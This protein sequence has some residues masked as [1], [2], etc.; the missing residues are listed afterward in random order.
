[1]QRRKISIL[2]RDPVLKAYLEQQLNGCGCLEI[3]ESRVRAEATVM[4]HRLLTENERQLLQKVADC[5][6]V[7]AAARAIPRSVGTLKRELATIREKLGVHTTLEAIVWAF[8][9]GV[10]R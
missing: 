5:G 8:R 4:E 10:I 6:S 3:V 9:H 7:E 2:A 1:M